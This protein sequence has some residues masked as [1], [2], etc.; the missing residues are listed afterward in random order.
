M[1]LLTSTAQVPPGGSAERDWRFCCCF[2]T[3]GTQPVNTAGSKGSQC[4]TSNELEQTKGICCKQWLLLQVMVGAM[5]GCLGAK[6]PAELVQPHQHSQ[7][8]RCCPHAERQGLPTGSKAGVGGM[9]GALPS[10]AL[11]YL[12]HEVLASLPLQMMLYFNACYF[13]FW[14]LGEGMMLQLKVLSGGQVG[15][16]LTGQ[17]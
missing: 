1:A 12:A 3:A 16:K 7:G 14:C 13:P 4:P 2:S 8:Q 11:P 5:P 9:L 10:P 6:A 17:V 15:G